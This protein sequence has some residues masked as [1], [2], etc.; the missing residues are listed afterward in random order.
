[1]VMNTLTST[2]NYGALIALSC[3]NAAL[4]I[5]AAPSCSE[6]GPDPGWPACAADGVVVGDELRG[7]L[8]KPGQVTRIVLADEAGARVPVRDDRLV[9]QLHQDGRRDGARAG[10]GNVGREWHLDGDRLCLKFDPNYRGQPECGWFEVARGKLFLVGGEG[11][12]R[13]VDGIDWVAH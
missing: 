2:L 11:R 10:S 3:C 12:R 9:A 8:F 4:Q 6:S 1:M 13:A 5:A 7:R